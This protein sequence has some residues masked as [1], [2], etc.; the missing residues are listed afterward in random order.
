MSEK[1][2]DTLYVKLVCV[3]FLS[4]N[5]G[6]VETASSYSVRELLELAVSAEYRTAIQHMHTGKA[7]S[8][9]RAAGS[10]CSS[11]AVPAL[12]LQPDYSDGAQRLCAS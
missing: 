3:C 4:C 2:V 10:S 5:H 12:L 1:C 11:L 8:S 6:M 9:T 7:L